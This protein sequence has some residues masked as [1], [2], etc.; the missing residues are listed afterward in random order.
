MIVAALI[1]KIISLFLILFAGTLLVR[2]RILK[3]EDSKVFSLLTLY[4]IVPC[5]IINA[6]QVEF[7]AGIKNGL[8]LALCAALVIQLGTIFFSHLLKRPLKLDP[9]EQASAVYPNAA[10]LVIPLVSAMLG[11]EW[12]IFTCP[13][14]ALQL[15]LIWSHGKSVLCGERG[16][17]L[18][19]IITNT[20]LIAVFVGVLM[21]LTGF[22]FPAPIQDAVG[23]VSATVGPISMLVTGMIIGGMDMKKVFTYKR[24]WLVTF[25]RL[26]LLPIPA[27]LLLKF[28]GMASL[29]QNGET[30]L[31]IVLMASSTPTA[32][33]VTQMSQVY[34]QDADYASAINV[35]TTLMCIF[36]LP[37]IVAL[38]QL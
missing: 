15:F 21:L 32:S 4:L 20:N 35:V 29:V 19:K 16:F 23:S 17:S 37:V 2:L 26:V 25:L 10:N 31:L 11:D 34:G 7:S 36:T 5:V 9:V 28:S 18:K 30:V 22:S 14:T 38:Y 1:K 3:A 6:F 8:L 33:M 12:I 13:F 27:L 24:V